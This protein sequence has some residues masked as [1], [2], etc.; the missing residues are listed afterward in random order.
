MLA[1]GQAVLDRGT[2]T[3]SLPGGKKLAD[4]RRACRDGEVLDALKKFYPGRPKIDVIPL[5]NTGSSRDRA[6]AL[7]K[8]AL[9]DPTIHNI[10]T[11]LEATLLR[12]VPFTDGD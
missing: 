1:T 10:I 3:I 12:V 5:P 2:L 9:A 6:S 7:E 8:Q 11:T 4:G